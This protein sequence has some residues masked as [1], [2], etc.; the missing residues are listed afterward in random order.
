M[1]P[2]PIWK[3]KAFCVFIIFSSPAVYLSHF[4]R[5][6]YCDCKVASSWL[7]MPSERNI[8]TTGK[9]PRRVKLSAEHKA[10]LRKL[11]ND[12]YYS[13]QRAVRYA[14]KGKVSA[15]FWRIRKHMKRLMHYGYTTDLSSP[16]FALPLQILMMGNTPP[17]RSWR[18][19]RRDR[20]SCRRCHLLPPLLLMRSQP[21]HLV[22]PVP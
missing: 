15:K 17:W 10:R 22:V 13:E 11:A 6:G 18:L 2:W 1:H 7:T 4:I 20:R 5:P 3:I 16:S 8:C 14:T 19:T 12:R 21:H 9:K